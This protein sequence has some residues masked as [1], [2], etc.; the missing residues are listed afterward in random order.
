MRT[1]PLLHTVLIE[2]DNALFYDLWLFCTQQSTEIWRFHIPRE[3]IHFL[4]SYYV[5][6]FDPL[7]RILVSHFFVSCIYKV[8]IYRYHVFGI[9][10]RYFPTNHSLLQGLGLNSLGV[11]VV[12][13]ADS[14]CGLRWM[15]RSTTDGRSR[16]HLSANLTR[17]IRTSLSS[18]ETC[19][20]S[21]SLKSDQSITGH[22]IK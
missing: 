19:S 10:T 5:T 2:R 6:D 7:W 11:L 4:L 22:L 1:L 8:M 3:I 9:F 12:A 15:F 16:R 21:F 17:L 20:L 14:L 13:G 18:S